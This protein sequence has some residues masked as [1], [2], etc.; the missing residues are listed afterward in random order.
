MHASPVIWLYK[1]AEPSPL[2]RIEIY[3]IFLGVI[4]IPVLMWLLIAAGFSPS[5]YG[6]N[7]PVERMRFL[8]RTIMIAAFML[9]GALFGVL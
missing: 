1:Q 8:A 3:F 5:V 6:Q 2:S 7:F 4:A 9:E